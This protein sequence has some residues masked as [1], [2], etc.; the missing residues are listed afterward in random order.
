MPGCVAPLHLAAPRRKPAPA[1][2]Q[3]RAPPPRP[4][5]ARR[6]SCTALSRAA[7]PRLLTPIIIP[8]RRSAC[9]R[10]A[11]DVVALA[12][13]WHDA[14]VSS[15]DQ[16]DPARDEGLVQPEVLGFGEGVCGADVT[17]PLTRLALLSQTA[18][19][20]SSRARLPSTT[21]P[22]CSTTPTLCTRCVFA[23]HWG[24]GVRAAQRRFSFGCAAATQFLTSVVALG[25]SITCSEMNMDT[26]NPMTVRVSRTESF[27]FLGGEVQPLAHALPALALLLLSTLGQLAGAVWHF[28]FSK[29][30]EF[31]DTVCSGGRG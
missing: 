5:S 3:P 31:L 12:D 10:L 18:S 16:A 20:S 29:C 7:I 14:V 26:E 17:D 4:Y 9:G 1:F 13:D 15:A 24:G 6:R 27:F 19:R 30:I 8:R 11:A 2:A 21:W 28:Y 25:M 23:F 22:W